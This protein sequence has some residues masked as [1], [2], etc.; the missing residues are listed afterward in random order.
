M[1]DWART[2]LLPLLRDPAENWQPSDLLPDPASPDFEDAVRELRRRAAG[3]PDDF[4]VALVGD[5]VTE[6]ALPSY[7]NMLNLLDGTKDETGADPSP[8]ATWTRAWTAEENRHGDVLHKWLYLSGRADM[9]SVQGTVQ[10]LVGNGLDPRLENNPYLCFVY[11]SFQER[12]TKVSHGSTARM[13]KERGDA[14]LARICGVIAADEGRHEEAYKRIIDQVLARD[15]D[16]AVLAFADMMRKGVLMPAHLM[17][18]GAHAG[19]NGRSLFADYAAVAERAGVYT[20][21]DYADIVDHLVARWG[22][23]GREGLSGEAAAAQEFLAG[24]AARVRRLAQLADERRE[25]ARRRGRAGASASFAW[26]R[27]REVPLS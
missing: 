25:R 17:D 11:T 7:M 13:A 9:R 23:A 18:D 6:E 5:M 26:L 20:A 16:G 10:R 21:W 15:P 14:G 1:T 8:W 2:G 24:H 27:G 22:V 3:L 19:A 12:A 4:L